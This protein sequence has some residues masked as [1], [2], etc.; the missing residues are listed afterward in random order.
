MTKPKRAGTARLA[1]AQAI[2]SKVHRLDM[3][4][5]LKLA[6]DLNV[7]V[8]TNL[9]KARRSQRH[10]PTQQDDGKEPPI[11]AGEGVGPVVSAAEGSRL[12]GAIAVDDD[13]ADWV[14]SELLGAGELVKRLEIS[15]GTLDNWRKAG[16][17]I[18]FRKGLRNYVYP[19][20]QFHHLRPID[21]L[22]CVTAHFSSP[23][24]SW[25]WLVSPNKMTQGKPPI[26][27][28][29]DGGV[30]PVVVAAA[31]AFDFA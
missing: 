16:K 23:E 28:L 19:I 8:P 31:G 10:S 6:A 7:K 25:E 4:S 30:E 3:D 27:M 5:L 11:L 24:E 12:L 2:E 9:T 15:R 21:G 26:E 20:R 22:D 14:E 18:A 1:L 17:I 13:S 29:R